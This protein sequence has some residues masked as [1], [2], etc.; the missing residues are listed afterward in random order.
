MKTVFSVQQQIMCSEILELLSVSN[1]YS[2]QTKKEKSSFINSSG[3]L[4]I[5]WQYK[6]NEMDMLLKPC[7][8]KKTL[9]SAFLL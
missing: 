4:K 7:V 9:R 5:N 6:A 3:S 1:T 8:L 2:I